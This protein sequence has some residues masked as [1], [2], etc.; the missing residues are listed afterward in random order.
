MPHAR[1]NG[2]ET[3]YEVRGEGPPLLFIHGGYGGAFSSLLPAAEMAG[4]FLAD[5]A[6]TITYDRRCAGRSEYILSEYTNDDLAAD[7]AALL[8]H[9]D[10][11]TAIVIGS[12]AGGPIALQFAL[13]WPGR[14]TALGLPNTGAALMSLTPYPEGDARLEPTRERLALVRERMLPIERARTEGDRPLFESRKAALRAPPTEEDISSQLRPRLAEL[15]AALEA[16]SDDDLFTYSTGQLRNMAAASGV[17]LT[18]RLGE[19]AMPTLI[20]HG[21]ADELVPFQFGLDLAAGIPHA[22]FHEI[23]GA[24]HGISNHPEA[25]R[26]MCD[27]VRQQAP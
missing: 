7:A 23:D 18:G 20:V 3:Y 15:T 14:V 8:D 9:L 10:V 16:V 12:S 11:A 4:S 5:T 2:V 6:R 22:E 24:G 27:W 13:S 25:R 19:L 17:N 26:I 1:V 21:T